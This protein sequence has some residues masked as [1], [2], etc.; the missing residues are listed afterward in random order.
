MMIPH[1]EGEAP[2][3]W[4]PTDFLDEVLALCNAYEASAD[5]IDPQDWLDQL[6]ERN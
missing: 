1:T 6:N 2:T 5:G 3:S 4:P